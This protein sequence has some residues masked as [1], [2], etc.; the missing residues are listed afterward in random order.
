MFYGPKSNFF[1]Q[2]LRE[3]SVLATVLPVAMAVR[4]LQLGRCISGV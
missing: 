1:P 2:L 3:I 4:P